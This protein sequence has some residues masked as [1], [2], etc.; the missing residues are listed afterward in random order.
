MVQIKVSSNLFARL[1]RDGLGCGRRSDTMR[2]PPFFLGA[3]V[4]LRRALLGALIDGDGSVDAFSGSRTYVKRGRTWTRRMNTACVSYFT[5]S[6]VLLQ[7]A[8]MLMHSLGMVPS[9]KKGKPELRLYG[10][11]ALRQ[12]APLLRGRKA[13]RLAHYLAR[14]AKRMPVKKVRRHGSYATVVPRA[15]RK[16]GGD[17]VYSIEVAGTHTYVTSYGLVSHNCIPID[18]FYLSWKARASGF[19]ARFIELA[20]HVNAHMPDHVCDLVAESLNRGGRAVRGS[21]VLVLGVAYK[22]G[23]DDTRESPSLDIMTTLERRGAKVEYSD[24]FVAKLAFAGR[25]LTSVPLTPARLRRFDCV[26]IA[27]AHRTFPYPQIVRHARGIVDTRNVLKGRRS[28]KI[29]RL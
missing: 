23:I 27:T 6:P 22:A 12:L 24:P 3:P 25:S 21:R 26:V 15:S 29:V 7:Q 17:Y 16:P 9:V 1:L 13:E 19:E 5:S 4:A 10:D 8:T 2:M 14:R 20:G 28:R 11:E 18:P